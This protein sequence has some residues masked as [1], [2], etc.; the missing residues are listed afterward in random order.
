MSSKDN[1]EPAQ[2]NLP[3]QLD[4]AKLATIIVSNRHPTEN[5]NRAARSS[6]KV[7]LSVWMEAG[8]AIED[9]SD[10]S[11]V[12]RKRLD[13]LGLYGSEMV[14]WKSL[15]PAID[16]SI[17]KL[18]NMPFEQFLKSCIGLTEKLDRV[19]WFRAFIRGWEEVAEI[20]REGLEDDLTFYGIASHDPDGTLRLKQLNPGSKKSRRAPTKTQI[21]AEDWIERFREKGVDRPYSMARAFRQWRLTMKSKTAKAASPVV[22][23]EAIFKAIQKK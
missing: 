7:A 4:L 22:L 16:S 2:G 3:S 23:E 5:S 12:E 14:L 21:K 6:V 18:D 11:E 8:K 1:S 20:G 13:F 17:A 19:S 15:L 9:I 10:L